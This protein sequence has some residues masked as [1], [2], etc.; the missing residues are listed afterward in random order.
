LEVEMSA[1]PP[2]TLFITGVSSGLGRALTEA[3][4]GAGHTV[5]GTVRRPEDA[6]AIDALGALAHAEIVEI[7][8]DA[9]VAAAVARTEQ[10]VG[11][12]DVLVANAGYGHEG[13]MEESTMEDLRRQFD[14]NVFGAVATIR[15]ALPS[16]RQ[17]RSGHVIGITSM[18]G[19][20]TI[21]GLTFYHGS[22]FA[23]EGILGSLAKEVAP[24]GVKVTAVAPGSFRTEWA[25]RSMVR[26]ASQLADYEPIFAPLRAARQEASGNQLGDPDRAAQVLLELIAMDRPPAHLLLGSDAIKLVGED[27]ARVDAEL[28]EWEAL[29]RSTDFAT[30]AQLA[31][32]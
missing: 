5:V 22:K 19:L 4:V 10:E 29:S 14:V 2:R 15:A 3:A 18:A 26:A 20:M 11:P 23:L 30:G 1:S 12:I 16:M 17:R 9:A 28:A 8:D 7:T 32:T 6:E 25:G 13:T 27:R 24:L 31:S 21:P